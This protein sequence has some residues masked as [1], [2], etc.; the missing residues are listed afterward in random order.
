MSLLLVLTVSHLLI[1]TAHR[2]CKSHRI[3]FKQLLDEALKI[4]GIINVKVLSAEAVGSHINSYH[5][6]IKDSSRL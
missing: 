5:F 3:N 1:K 2:N 4:S 6:F